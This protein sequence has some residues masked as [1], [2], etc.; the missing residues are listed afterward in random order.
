MD[1][2]NNINNAHPTIAANKDKHV[3]EKLSHQA[4]LNYAK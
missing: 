1:G 3:D 4:R 2:P